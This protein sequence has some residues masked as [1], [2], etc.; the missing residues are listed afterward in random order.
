MW[1]LIGL[2]LGTLVSE[3]AA[4]AGAGGLARTGTL[5]PLAAGLAVAMGIWVGDV[6]L[7]AAGR[8]AAHSAPIARFVERRWPPTELQSLAT[9]LERQAGWAILLSRALP[10]TR[11]PLYVAAGALRLRIAVFL[12]SSAAAVAVWT[13]AIV[14]GMQWLP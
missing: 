12:A 13:A 7:F 11:V 3:D 14:G 9:R 5:S 1:I 6:L 8:L 10:G 2:A 4:L